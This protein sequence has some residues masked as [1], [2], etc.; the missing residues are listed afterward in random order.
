M[1]DSG[2]ARD[3][4]PSVATV[5]RVGSLQRAVAAGGLVV[6]LLVLTV[7]AAMVGKQTSGPVIAPTVSP[8]AARL[9]SSEPAPALAPTRPGQRAR[10]GCRHGHRLP[11]SFD[12]CD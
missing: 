10:S 5:A 9:A 4:A 3:D 12:K 11:V 8:A 2:P 7:T 1:S 6:A